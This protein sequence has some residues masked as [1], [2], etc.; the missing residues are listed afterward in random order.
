MLSS[1][2][3]LLMVINSSMNVLFYGF[4]NSQFREVAKKTMSGFFGRS[5]PTLQDNNGANRRSQYRNCTSGV[6]PRMGANSTR[7]LVPQPPPPSAGAPPEP[8]S[9]PLMVLQAPDFGSPSSIDTTSYGQVSSADV[10]SLVS[11][12]AISEAAG[13]EGPEGRLGAEKVADSPADPVCQATSQT[14]KVATSTKTDSSTQLPDNF[15]V[16]MSPQL[17]SP[18]TDAF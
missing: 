15:R 2:S 17:T 9:S 3:H 5:Q 13:S 16:T 8:L 14:L 7:A 12:V 4:F 6:Q 18:T 1:F 11:K 10:G